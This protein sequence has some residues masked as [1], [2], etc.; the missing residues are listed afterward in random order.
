MYTS[1]LYV[2]FDT[3]T[4]AIFVMVIESN[5]VCTVF[6]FAKTFPEIEFLR[7]TAW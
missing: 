5:H 1:I 7:T 6:R 3:W 4:E 2:I